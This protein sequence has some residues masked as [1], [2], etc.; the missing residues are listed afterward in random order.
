M[1]KVLVLLISVG[2]TWGLV[3][4]LGWVSIAVCFA[5]ALATLIFSTETEESEFASSGTAEG[6]RYFAAPATHL[7]GL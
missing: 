6:A 3:A 1:A 4:S 7:G 5:L 2:M